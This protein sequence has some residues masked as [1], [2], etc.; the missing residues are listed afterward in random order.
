V[1]GLIGIAL[2][3]TIAIA[4]ATREL[5]DWATTSAVAVAVLLSLRWVYRIGRG[6]AD[7][8]RPASVSGRVLRIVPFGTFGDPE[9]TLVLTALYHGPLSWLTRRVGAPT[10]TSD[11]TGMT[12]GFF[13]VLDDGTSAVAQAWLATPRRAGRLQL[14]DDVTAKVQRWTKHLISSSA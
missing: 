12:P 9:T 5:S 6:V 14:G 11:G 1:S 2:A 4:V 3:A 10:V 7:L 13:V 8:L